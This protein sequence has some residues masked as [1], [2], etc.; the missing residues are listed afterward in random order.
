MHAFEANVLRKTF[1]DV[2]L[3]PWNPLTILENCQENCPAL[4]QLK[5]SRFV[6]QLLKIINTIDQEKIHQMQQV[7]DEMKVERVITQKE[8][9]EKMAFEEQLLKNLFGLKI[10]KKVRTSVKVRDI[11]A[12][13]HDELVCTPKRGRGR[14]RKNSMVN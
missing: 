1:A 11:S 5:E 13:M 2:G 7:I 3:W 8:V 6:R 10:P 14:P 4:P 12:E 9:E